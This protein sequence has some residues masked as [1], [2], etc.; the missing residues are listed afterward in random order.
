MID[1][2]KIADIMRRCVNEA[3]GDSTATSQYHQRILE[4]ARA[5]I[6]QAATGVENGSIEIEDLIALAV[7]HSMAIAAQAAVVS[8]V[9]K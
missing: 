8:E 9:L 5:D 6:E 2:Q 7:V 1:M 3:L 4:K